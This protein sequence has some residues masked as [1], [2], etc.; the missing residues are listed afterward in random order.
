[1]RR[2]AI[3]LMFYPGHCFC[4][5]EL[6]EFVNSIFNPKLTPLDIALFVFLVAH[7]LPKCEL[8]RRSLSTNN[9]I[10][11]TQKKRLFKEQSISSNLP[12]NGHIGTREL[13]FRSAISGMCYLTR[14]VDCMVKRVWFRRI[15]I[16][17]KT[18][19]LT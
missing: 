2:K 4:P 17:A 18:T 1:M 7:G 14:I 16:Y 3:S 8:N 5:D 12:S 6:A 19:P 10:S 9:S 11:H 13:G 15:S